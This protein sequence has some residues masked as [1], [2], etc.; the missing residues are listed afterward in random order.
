MPVSKFN[1][2]G[3]YKPV[4]ELSRETN[5]R[6]REVAQSFAR[7]ALRH[8]SGWSA[9]AN[10]CLE[11]ELTWVGHRADHQGTEYRATVT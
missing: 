9:P 6:G 1:P 5:R 10:P 8:R 7:L 2:T 11:V 3:M 4:T